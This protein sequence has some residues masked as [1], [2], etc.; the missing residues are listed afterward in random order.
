MERINKDVFIWFGP[1]KGIKWEDC[2]IEELEYLSNECYSR[3]VYKR[4]EAELARRRK[5]K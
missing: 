1:Y 5:K 2:P 4:A 3:G